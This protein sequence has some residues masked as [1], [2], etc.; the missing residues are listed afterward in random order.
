MIEFKYNEKGEL[1]SWKDGKKI[2]KINQ[3]PEWMFPNVFKKEPRNYDSNPVI[4]AMIERRSCKSFDPEKEVDDDL[5]EQIVEAGTYAA[6]GRAKQSPIIVVVKDKDMIRKLSKLNASIWGTD[7]DTF[8]GATAL[9]I[10]F[11]DS[12]IHTYVEDGS[13]VIGNLML[14]AHSLNVDSCWIH[15]ARE[16]FQTEEGKYLMKKWGIAEKYVGIGN[17]VLGYR[18]KDLPKAKERKPDYVRYVD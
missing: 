11:A 13:L 10:V 1:E 7:A 2:G 12:E 4:K 5:I 15:R 9:L 14:A 6:N 3:T 17:C 8:Y 16:V 18:N